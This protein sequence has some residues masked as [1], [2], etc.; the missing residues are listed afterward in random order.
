[1][2]THELRYRGDLLRLGTPSELEQHKVTLLSE[3]EDQE[4]ITIT[5]R[6]PVELH[7]RGVFV[8]TFST[9]DDAHTYLAELS[10]DALARSPLDVWEV[11]DRSAGEKTAAECVTGGEEPSP[12]RL[13]PPP[14]PSSTPAS[15]R[16]EVAA[17]TAVAAAAK[18][19]SVPP[20]AP[21]KPPPTS[22]SRARR[23]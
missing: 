21:P 7:C 2:A 11:V 1:M 6:R 4:S 19:P 23:A 15:W 17:P 12:G 20:P 16:D 13:L 10:T 3:H 14:P 22:P 9:K 18:P 8:D 5:G